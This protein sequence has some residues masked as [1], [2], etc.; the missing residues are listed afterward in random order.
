MS[1]VLEF[2]MATWT[3]SALRPWETLRHPLH[4]AEPSPSPTPRQGLVGVSA[5]GSCPLPP[6]LGPR[7]VSI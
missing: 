1:S 5:V 4:A 6:T 3:S 2:S 7:R